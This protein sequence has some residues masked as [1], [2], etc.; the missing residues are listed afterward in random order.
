M[1][2]AK[3]KMGVSLALSCG[4]AAGGACSVETDCLGFARDLVLEPRGGL[5]TELLCHSPLP[6]QD[7]LEVRGS[8]HSAK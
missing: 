8:R 1:A 7:S 3:A 2:W 4:G 6:N 5:V